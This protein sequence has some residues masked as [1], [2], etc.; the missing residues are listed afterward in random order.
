MSKESSK[1]GQAGVEV[2]PEMIEAG[3]G[4]LLD[5]TIMFP[6]SELGE[7]EQRSLVERV[8]FAMAS[9]KSARN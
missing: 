3:R 2:S 4:A 9:R 1:N 8:Y 7:S 6:V 5:A